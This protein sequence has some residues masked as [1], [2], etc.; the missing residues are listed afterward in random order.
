MTIDPPIR[1][2]LLLFSLRPTLHALVTFG[3]ITI[4]GTFTF[5]SGSAEA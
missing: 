1:R 3:V 4:L 2:K 5:M